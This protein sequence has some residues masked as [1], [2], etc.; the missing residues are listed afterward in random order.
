LTS[1]RERAK[2]LALIFKT[3]IVRGANSSVPTIGHFEIPADDVERAK[4]FYSDLFEWKIEKWDDPKVGMDYLLINTTDSKGNKGLGGGIIKRRH[5]K[6]SVTDYVEVDSIDKYSAKVT[7]LGGKI[8]V[9]KTEI[10]TVGYFAVFLDTE[11]NH[12]GMFEA[13]ENAK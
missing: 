9:P 3:F 5:P 7:A 8:V 13:S 6:H 1:T 2:S 12:F 11:N 4:K 10:P